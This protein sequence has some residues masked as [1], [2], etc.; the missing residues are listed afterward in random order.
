MEMDPENK[1]AEQKEEQPKTCEGC[2]AMCC[3]Y[4]ALEIDTPEDVEDF[5]NI[6]WYVCHKN[7]NVFVD[8]E[9]EWHLEFI[10]PCQYLDEK[11]WCTIY[12]RRPQ[13]CRDY[14]QDECLFHNDDYEEKYKFDKIE[15]VEYYVKNVF[16]K[17]LHEFPEEDEESEDE[18]EEEDESDEDSDT[19]NYDQS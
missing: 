14:N 15:D 4:V 19:E 6:K 12:E 11:G 7:V 17:G 10:T 3:K 1:E 9:G 8:Q 18:D 16:D 2:D 5:E 13:I